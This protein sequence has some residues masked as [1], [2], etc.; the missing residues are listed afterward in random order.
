MTDGNFFA[1]I[2]GI[3]VV[4]ER[5]FRHQEGP[6]STCGRRMSGLALLLRGVFGVESLLIMLAGAMDA[7]ST[8]QPLLA[9][10]A[11]VA[12]PMTFFGYPSIGGL[13]V[14]WLISMAAFIGG[15]VAAAT[16]SRLREGKASRSGRCQRDRAPRSA[17]L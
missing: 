16:A 8:G 15:T 5:Q 14:L 3:N 1:L 6:R 4:C 17:H 13:Q 11:F 10:I 2:G 7:W 12:Y 9:G